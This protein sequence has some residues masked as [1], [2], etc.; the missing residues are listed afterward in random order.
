MLIK[1]SDVKA[2]MAA[3]RARH[4]QLLTNSPSLLGSPSVSTKPEPMRANA[5]GS[6]LEPIRLV[7]RVRISPAVRSVLPAGQRVPAPAVE[8]PTH[9]SGTTTV[10]K[11]SEW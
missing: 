7:P 3:R 11:P 4:L 10:F 1:K 9:C 6:T 5:H 2:H 8:K